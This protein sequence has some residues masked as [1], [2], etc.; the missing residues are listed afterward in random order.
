MRGTIPSSK[1][2]DRLTMI[3]IS[4]YWH[5]NKQAMEKESSERE[6]SPF[7]HLTYEMWHYHL[8]GKRWIH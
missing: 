1:I 7:E 6:P 3:K 4:W 2:C 5:I 8:V